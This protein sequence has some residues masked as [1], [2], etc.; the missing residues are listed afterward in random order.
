MTET[1]FTGE[2]IDLKE[3]ILT[4]WR[5]KWLIVGFSL[6][7]GLLAFLIS[8]YLIPKKFQASAVITITERNTWVSMEVKGLPQLA[9]SDQLLDQIYE[10]FGKTDLEGEL[11]SDLT[12]D[13]VVRS[14]LILRV[15]AEEP[16]LAAEAANR[17]AELV[18]DKL[19]ALYGTSESSLKSLE[20]QVT[21]A[22]TDWSSAQVAL[23]EY[24]SESQQDLYTAQ[25]SAAQ[26]A[27]VDILS[28]IERN[29]LLI[30]DVA[31]IEAQLEGLDPTEPLNTGIALSLII[32]Q[33]RA[34]TGPGELISTTLQDH[35]LP[36]DLSIAEAVLALNQFRTALEDQNQWLSGEKASL[37]EDIS[38]LAVSYEEEENKIEKL[39]VERNLAQTN[40][41]ALARD[42]DKGEAL[43]VEEASYIVV[44]S[45]ALPPRD[46]ISPNVIANTGF[47]GVS[48]ALLIMVGILFYEWWVGQ[49]DK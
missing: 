16:D 4:L 37:E 19:N 30:S 12:A 42:L 28:E 27:L 25:L 35:A 36:A 15:T 7:F 48:A 31:A 32:L 11:L 24:L 17:W 5:K 8:S 22:E 34:A 14:Q 46:P 20:E 29:Q 38:R 40:Y 6:L 10:E 3:L 1:T 43:Q 33:G 47:A 23:E 18:V 21:K 2:V 9:A 41:N 44:S 13:A 45:S 39:K 49:E 26:A